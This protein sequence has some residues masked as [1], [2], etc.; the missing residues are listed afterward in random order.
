MI[1]LKS[2]HIINYKILQDF[3]LTFEDRQA[4]TVLLGTNGAGKSTVLECL[5]WIVRGLHEKYLH[6]Q[7]PELPFEF[8]L[9]YEVSSIIRTELPAQTWEE[10][11]PAQVIV[12][13]SKG[14]DEYELDLAWVMS[15]DDSKPLLLAYPD[16]EEELLQQLPNLAVYYSG[17]SETIEH[18]YTEYE[19]KQLDSSW[20][21]LQQD[22]STYA[23]ATSLPLYYLQRNDFPLLLAALFSFEVN[24]GLDDFL[25]RRM[26]G[27]Q[28]PE[29]ICITVVVKRP[30][31]Y[32]GSRT[33]KLSKLLIEGEVDFWG[34]EGLLRQFL[35]Q[36]SLLATEKQEVS[37]EATYT[38]HFNIAAWYSLREANN[39][40]HNILALLLLLRANDT[41][42]NVQVLYRRDNLVAPHNTLSEGEQ[43]LLIVRALNELLVEERTIILLDEPDTFLHPQWQEKFIDEIVPF[44]KE[45]SF[46]ITTHSPVILTHINKG[47]IIQ[48]T[49]GKGQKLENHVFGQRYADALINYMVNTP[50]PAK[51]EAELNIVFNLIEREDWV[52]AVSKL[53]DL[54]KQL[55]AHDAD[56][57]RAEKMI[58]LF[59]E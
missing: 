10:L 56:V 18:I 25:A 26:R 17:L 47:N 34:T 16:T 1:R 22:A 37:S 58:R 33:A 48:M 23:R 39:S 31:Y 28:K 55:G 2:L 21:K 59:S 8:E 35:Q 57:V 45:A 24:F 40:E 32:T 44:T 52:A 27:L 4:I 6:K 7:K 50:R 14:K 19:S 43:Q 13:G 51:V 49:Y 41:L 29:G 20:R 9:R 15:T 11:S 46:I 5:A 42:A 3:K 12:T 36:M 54:R 30:A 38:Y 53:K